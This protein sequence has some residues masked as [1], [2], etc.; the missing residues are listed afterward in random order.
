MKMP[1]TEPAGLVV[2]R[3]ADVIDVAYIAVAV[4]RPVR[5][6]HRSTDLGR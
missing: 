2:S 5:D 4:I 1:T 6:P 3:A